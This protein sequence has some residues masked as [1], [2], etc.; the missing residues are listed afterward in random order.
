MAM[1][2]ILQIM[3]EMLRDQPVNASIRR[4]STESDYQTREYSYLES[5]IVDVGVVNS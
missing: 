1:L 4:T 3:R 5:N 2:G